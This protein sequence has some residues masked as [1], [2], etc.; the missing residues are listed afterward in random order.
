MEH[1]FVF[2]LCIH[3]WEQH[4]KCLTRLRLSPISLFFLFVLFCFVFEAY[5]LLKYV[6]TWWIGVCIWLWH[7]WLWQI[8]DRLHQCRCV[9]TIHRTWE[10]DMTQTCCFYV[11]ALFSHF[12]HD[13]I[14]DMVYSC[15]ANWITSC[16]L[17]SCV[18]YSNNI[19]QS[20][21]PAVQHH[22][23]VLHW[24]HLSSHDGMQH[25]S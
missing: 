11:Q 17:S 21:Q 5:T 4:F 13:C 18:R 14:E 6:V 23:R 12:S 16:V 3:C 20:Y 15:V 8:Q 2:R 22:L 24:G 25:V 7:W 9:F 19:L 1:I 10:R